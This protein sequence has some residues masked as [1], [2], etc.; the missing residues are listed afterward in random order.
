VNYIINLTG[1]TH[2]MIT[3]N[4][5]QKTIK[6]LIVLTDQNDKRYIK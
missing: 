4:K 3:H 2:V 1:E 5:V 6:F